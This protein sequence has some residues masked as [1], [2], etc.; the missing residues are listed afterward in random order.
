VTPTVD[1]SF[2]GIVDP[3]RMV[4]CLLDQL[5]ARVLCITPAAV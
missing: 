2:A 3:P 4:Q 1:D 5:A